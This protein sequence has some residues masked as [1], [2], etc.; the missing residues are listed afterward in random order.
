[1]GVRLNMSKEKEEKKQYVFLFSS[2]E[3]PAY[4]EDNLKILCYPA[5]YIIHFRYDEKYVQTDLNFN[6]LIDKEA[7]LVIV[8]RSAPPLLFPARK[9]FIK[10]VSVHGS[11]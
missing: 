2:D 8:G 11:I 6:S 4:K 5:G 10:K 7:V 9:A 3:R 1:M